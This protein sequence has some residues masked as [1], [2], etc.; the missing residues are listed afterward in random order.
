MYK[1]SYTAM[2]REPAIR[3]RGFIVPRYQGY[4]P[5][6][7]ADAELGRTYSKVAARCFLK[8]INRD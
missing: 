1:T 5:C 2:K 3:D 4:I 6:M 8:R 7:D